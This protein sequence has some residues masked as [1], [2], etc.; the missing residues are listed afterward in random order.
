MTTNEFKDCLVSYYQ[1][2]VLG[3]AFF[4]ALLIK[5]SDPIHRYKIASLVLHSTLGCMTPIDYEN[6]LYDV[7][8]IG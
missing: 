1:T 4:E 2:E 8:G 3:E 6:F 5:F 7:S